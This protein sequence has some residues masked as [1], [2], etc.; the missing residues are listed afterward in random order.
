MFLRL[1]TGPIPILIE[2]ELDHP[3]TCVMS[4]ESDDLVLVY[5]RRIDAKIDRLMEDVQ[6]LKH[7]MESL[8]RQVEGLKS[9]MTAIR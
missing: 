6:D 8:E 3:Y 7:Q 2:S 5:L 1:N 9:E 4:D